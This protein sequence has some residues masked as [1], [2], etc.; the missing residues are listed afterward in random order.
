[1]STTASTGVV[2]T[3]SDITSGT[4]SNT[5]G[6]SLLVAM[7][8]AFQSQEGL[9]TLS[10]QGVIGFSSSFLNSSLGCLYEEMGMSAF[11]RLRLTN[12]KPAQLSQLKKYMADVVQLHDAE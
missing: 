6:F 7:K 11:K 1:M 10:L 8:N 5:D 4:Y 3:I 2:L 9:V 12:Y